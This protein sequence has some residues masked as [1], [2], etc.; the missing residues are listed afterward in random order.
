MLTSSYKYPIFQTF[1]RENAY[2]DQ[3]LAHLSTKCSGASC[4]D[5]AMS[6]RRASVHRPIVNIYLVDTLQAIIL[7]QSLSKLVKM[8]VWV[9]SR[10]KF[11]Y[12]SSSIINQASRSNYR[13]TSL[14][15]IF[16]E[17]FFVIGQNGCLGK[18]SLKFE[19]GSA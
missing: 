4:S 18:I 13:K 14:S 17:I 5:Q 11:E 8:F 3:F 2:T 12:G 9:R 16:S 19:Y 10:S 6:R 15:H 7:V 1:A